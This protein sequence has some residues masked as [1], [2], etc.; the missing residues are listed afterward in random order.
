MTQL[1]A[2]VIATL[3]APVAAAFQDDESDFWTACAK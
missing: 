1:G 3:E 2:Q